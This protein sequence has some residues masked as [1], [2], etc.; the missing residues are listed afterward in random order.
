MRLTFATRRIVAGEAVPNVIEEPAIDFV[1][2]F[3]LPRQ[4]HFEPGQRPLFQ[5][6]GQ[7]RVVRV[8]QRPRGQ[9]PGFVP[10]QFGFVEQNPHQFGNGHRRMRIVQLDGHFVRQ[11]VP[12]GV[13]SAETAHQIGE[14]AG[15]EKIFLHESQPLPHA[16]GVVGI[17]HARERIGRKRLGQRADEI[18]AAEFL[19]IEVVRRGR[20]PQPQRIDRFSAVADDRPIEGNADQARRPAGNRLQ[21]CRRA[22]RTSS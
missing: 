6:L 12:I 17:K 16:R 21:S 2:D 15:D 14:R 9:I 7:Q 1:D 18:A 5:R 3:Q 4:Q 19:E 8:G 10:A 13:G 22:A 20:G 11:R